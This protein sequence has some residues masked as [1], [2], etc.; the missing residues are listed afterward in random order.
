MMKLVVFIN[1]YYHKTVFAKYLRIWSISNVSFYILWLY[2]FKIS[3]LVLT[4][5]SGTNINWNIWRR[6]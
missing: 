4:L 2:I 1:Q 5:D 6:Y 3:P